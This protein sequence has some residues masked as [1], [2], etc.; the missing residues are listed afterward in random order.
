MRKINLFLWFFLLCNHFIAAQ[1]EA[2]VFI[3]G[4]CLMVPSQGYF[5]Q[6]PEANILFHFDEDTLV[7]VTQGIT[8]NLA[9][10]YSRAAFAHHT[11]GELLFASNGWRLINGSGQILTHKLWRNDVPWPEDSFD[12][13]MVLN[14]MGPLFLN[15]P[16]D[17]TKAYLF[18][19]QYL[20]GIAQNILPV[21][22][23]DRYFTYALLDLPSQSM[24]SKNNMVIDE[25]TG[26]GDMQACRH[27][28]GRDWWIIKPG[29]FED[30]LYVGLLDPQG[31]NMQKI[32]IPEMPH[33]GQL[34]TFSFFSMDGS[35]YLHFSHK[36]NKRL[37]VFDFDRCSGMLTYKS[38][39][40]LIDSLQVIDYNGCNISP[41][42][43]KF[44]VRRSNNFE[45][46]IIG[47]TCQYDINTGVFKR[48]ANVLSGSSPMLSPNGKHI[49]YN[50]SI[51]DG[52][53]LTQY[54]N[55]IVNPNEAADQLIYEF[56]ILVFTNN[57]T[58]VDP[59]CFAN[60]RLGKIVGSACDTVVSSIKTLQAESIK[61]FPNPSN[62]I[63]QVQLPES[64]GVFLTSLYSIMG[65]QMHQT[66]ISSSQSTID[67]SALGISPGMYLLHLVN[68]QKDKSFKTIIVYDK[69]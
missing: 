12:T 8:L 52:T 4:R 28:N 15:H 16:G 61:A 25:F 32:I 26:S 40:D 17:T 23:A 9:T 22:K 62:G 56:E 55:R 50:T 3:H 34:E 31:I 30:E 6:S 45:G 36:P 29:V 65:Q 67:L 48:L 59:S 47:G 53:T 49:Y 68:K 69:N 11:T 46:T 1:R 43:S 42:G 35:K 37:H 38:E 60:Y 18:Y 44:Y 20:K 21:G 27:A 66:Q 19:G 33:E 57:P 51:N 24:I 64:S 41:D 14:A 2:D 5:C 39:H 10:S 13:T 63:V 54:L 7:S 58:P